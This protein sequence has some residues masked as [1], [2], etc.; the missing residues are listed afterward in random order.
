MSYSAKIHRDG[1]LTTVGTKRGEKT[2]YQ[3]EIRSEHA[4]F[5]YHRCSF[6]CTLWKHLEAVMGCPMLSIVVV[7]EL[8]DVETRMSH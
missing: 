5:C 4:R 1:L 8:M 2:P 3:S 7:K 6:I